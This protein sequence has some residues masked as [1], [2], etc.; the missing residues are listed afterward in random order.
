[1]PHAHDSMFTGG[2]YSS[3]SSD[4]SDR[5]SDLTRAEAVRQYPEACHQVLA[6]TLGLVYSKIR[7]EAGEG[8]SNM[9][10]HVQK[11]AYDDASIQSSI[12]PKSSKVAR[13][14]HNDI[15]PARF[16]KMLAGA[17]T[18]D[19]KSTVSQGFDRLGWDAHSSQMSEETM[20][21]LKDIVA[22][23]VNARLR[24]M[25]RGAV[26]IQPNHAEQ[27]GRSSTTEMSVRTRFNDDSPAPCP[28]CD[29]FP[30][31][32]NTVATE[33]ISPVS[34]QDHSWTSSP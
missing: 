13:R 34:A 10:H 29:G 1:M 33:I 30:T 9:M 4:S 20:G 6:A 19:T 21:R 32:P 17:Q 7:N 3:D 22:E 18:I 2:G 23:E 24:A 14:S 27:R 25:E 28:S 15:S 31:E 8:P 12:R 11:R 26:R 5:P 16:H